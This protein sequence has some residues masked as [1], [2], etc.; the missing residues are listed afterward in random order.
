MDRRTVVVWKTA[1][2]HPHRKTG[3]PIICTARFDAP[4]LNFDF[5]DQQNNQA[6]L[7]LTTEPPD[8]VF[9]SKRIFREC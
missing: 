6:A 9:K 3:I 7:V 4:R 1:G 2:R 5:S 8:Y